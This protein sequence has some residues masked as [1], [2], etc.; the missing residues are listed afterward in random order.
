MTSKE[1]RGQEVVAFLRDYARERINSRLFDARRCIPPYVVLDFGREGL[2]GLG[3]PRELGGIGLTWRERI[4]V[5]Q[6]LAA[7]DLTL[8]MFVGIHNE[9]GIGPILKFGQPKLRETL[10]PPMAKGS[11]LGGLAIT[12]EGAGANPRAIKASAERR[13]SGGWR[14]N[15]EKIWVGNGSWAGVLN[16]FARATDGRA[17]RVL[18]FAVST[19]APGVRM[20]MEAMTLGMR[21]IVQ[22]SV[23]FSNV[24]VG[25]DHLLGDATAD[26]LVA[27]ASFRMARFGIA[28]AATGAIKRCLQLMLRYSTRR[29]IATGSLSDHPL[30]LAALS[31]GYAAAKILDRLT[32]LLADELDAE[33]DVPGELFV[34]C[35]ALAPEYL[36][37]AA[38]A[39]VQWLGGRGYVEANEAPQLLRDARLL[40]I[41]EGP[42]ETMRSH[43]GSLWHHHGS[44]RQFLGRPG[45]NV[46]IAAQITAAAEE[47]WTTPRHPSLSVGQYTSARYGAIGEVVADGVAWW[48]SDTPSTDEAIKEWA[49]RRF[50]AARQRAAHTLSNALFG[51]ARLP[52]ELSADIG[53]I[54]Q[55]LPGEDWRCDPLLQP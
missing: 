13:A 3:V 45:G 30:F 25:A 11:V 14:L 52:A 36:C 51:F 33:R 21:G 2:L 26:L 31:D 53:D 46:A 44:L 24:D 37:A 50:E 8:A 15:G 5:V 23:H 18:G 32:L 54:A 38:D 40:R 22:S 20:G 39:L 28:I 12:E 35:K 47:L 7:I 55:T 43:L 41:F 4:P 17:S 27:E 34:V 48:L 29:N 16:V 9:L 19:G 49:R 42:T 10:I 6:Q 1:T